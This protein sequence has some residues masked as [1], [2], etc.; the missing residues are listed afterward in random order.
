MGSLDSESIATFL[1]SGEATEVIVIVSLSIAPES[2]VE[3]TVAYVLFL[4]GL[5]S[6]DDRST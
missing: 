3:L 5:P 6:A 1:G 4:I 2:S